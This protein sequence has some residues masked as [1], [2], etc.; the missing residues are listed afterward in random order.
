MRTSIIA[1][2]LAVIT[3]PLLLPLPLFPIVAAAIQTNLV[4]PGALL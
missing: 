1:T 4:I 2:F 3:S